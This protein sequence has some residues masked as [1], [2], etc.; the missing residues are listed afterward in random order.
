VSGVS[1]DGA[2]DTHSGRVE[3]GRTPPAPPA[4]VMDPLE[5]TVQ[6]VLQ[7]GVT[8]SFALMAAGIVLDVVLGESLTPHV[9]PLREVGAGLA[10]PDP[11]AYLSLGIIVLIATP[12]VRVAGSLVAFVLLRDRR[13]AVVTAVVLAVMCVSVVLGRG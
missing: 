8:L 6:R 10:G 2:G 12:F 9:V 1:R 13:Y 4:H 7:A 3:G 11:A 5:R